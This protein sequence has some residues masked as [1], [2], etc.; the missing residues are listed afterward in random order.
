MKSYKIVFIGDASV[1][2]TSII[3]R[4]IHKRFI[5]YTNSTIG[6]SY[7][8]YTLD[9]E[10]DKIRINIWDTAGQERYRALISMYYRDI[11]SCIIVLDLNN[12]SAENIKY[13]INEFETKCN[14]ETLPPV[15][16]VGN[17]YDL[18]DKNLDKLA[19]IEKQ[20]YDIIEDKKHLKIDWQYLLKKPLDSQKNFFRFYSK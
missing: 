12:F 4:Y 15:I 8:S 13:W 11:S 10:D 3:N 20:D 5:F 2:K 6:A 9:T 1:G 16:L 7:T 14:K 18:L 19:K 17:K